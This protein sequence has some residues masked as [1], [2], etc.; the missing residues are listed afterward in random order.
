MVKYAAAIKRLERV[1][2]DGRKN[3]KGFVPPGLDDVVESGARL[4][5][6]L[7][8]VL[9]AWPESP[10]NR[11]LWSKGKNMLGQI[12]IAT[13]P[14]VKHFLLV[15]KDAAQVRVLRPI[16]LIRFLDTCLESLWIRGWRVDAI[17]NCFI[18]REF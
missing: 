2:E 14:F 17:H 1:V 6:Q 9:T 13:S 12:F 4:E 5:E 16:L 8:S 10:E 7:E 11:S 3:W 18:R 15:A